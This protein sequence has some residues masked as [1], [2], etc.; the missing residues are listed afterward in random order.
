MEKFVNILLEKCRCLSK[1]QGVV[2]TISFT[3]FKHVP[4]CYILPESEQAW[5]L[6]I[7]AHKSQSNPS[8]QHI[9][10]NGNINSSFRP[11]A[12]ESVVRFDL[13]LIMEPE[14]TET[15]RADV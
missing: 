4:A 3:W 7:E 13:V 1:V 8:N 15:G 6:N 2:I 10:L 9:H 14:P 5:I 12:V 11:M